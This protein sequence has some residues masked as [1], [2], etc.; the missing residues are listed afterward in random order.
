MTI[1][2]ADLWQELDQIAEKH[3]ITGQWIKGHS[4]NQDNERCDEMAEE[5]A[6]HHVNVILVHSGR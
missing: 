2:N 6:R 3:T 4:G 1:P 5:Q